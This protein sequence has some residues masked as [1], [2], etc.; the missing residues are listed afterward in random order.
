MAQKRSTFSVAFYIRRTR[1]NK[2]GEAAIVIRVTVDGIR[3][4]TTAKK[5][6]NPKLW[7]SAKGKAYERSLLAKEL[8][9]YLDSIRA[10]FIRIHRDF[11]Q[12]DAERITAEA[13][14]NRFLGK[15]KPERHTLLEVFR[16][17]NEKCHKLSGIG[18][19]P[20]TVERYETSF[21][22]TQEFI[23]QTYKKDDIYLDEMNRQFIEDY[24]LYLKT[25]RKC[26]HNS[27]TKY[28]KNFKKITRIAI[29]KEWLKKDPFIEI[30]FSLQI[31]ERD[32]LEKHEIEKIYNKEFTIERLAQVRDVFLFCCFSGLA[33]S[34]VKQLTHDHISI[35]TNGN[36]WIRKQRQK[37][38]NMCNIPLL[39]IPL[40]IIDK[41]KSHPRCQE[42]NVLLPVLCNQKMNAYIKEITDLCGINKQVS[43]HTARHTFATLMLANGVSIENVAKMLGHSDTKMTRHY[44]QILDSSIMRDMEKAQ[45]NI[46]FA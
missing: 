23:Q 13:V 17:H 31:V 37:T 34:D 19:S 4:D 10:K 46:R 9:M 39:E 30:K 3:G 43:T 40:K 45:D 44:A 2:H 32:F 8:N 35:D 11:E 16:E 41:Y 21:K 42:K 25:V 15:D 26:N 14:I 6:I 29:Q 36:K 1:L 28:L 24:E 12:D 20:A 33:F 27:T 22:H 38:K 7:D 5:T 18:M